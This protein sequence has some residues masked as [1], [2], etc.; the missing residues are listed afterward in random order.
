MNTKGATWQVADWMTKGNSDIVLGSGD[1]DTFL[2]AHG[3]DPSTLKQRQ[4]KALAARYLDVSGLS[5][6]SFR[7]AGEYDEG[8]MSS[9]DYAASFGRL[10]ELE[11]HTDKSGQL[12]FVPLTNGVAGA[13]FGK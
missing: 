3:V 11:K 4:R 8:H 7:Y 13:S 2:E 6:D 12:L 10:A 1:L 5:K 9:A